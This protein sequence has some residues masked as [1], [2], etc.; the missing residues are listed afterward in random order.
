MYDDETL[1]QQP[2]TTESESTH[3]PQT[4]QPTQEESIQAKNFK[5]LKDG[6]ER[7]RR[8][9]ER[10]ER[11]RDE[12][13]RRMAEMESRMRSNQGHEDEDVGGSDDDLIDKKSFRKG[14]ERERKKFSE[15]LRKQQSQME[16]KL[17]EDRLRMMYPDI[18]SVLS[19]ENIDTFRNIEPDMARTISASTDPYG[20]AVSAYKMIKK[21]GIHQDPHDATL[22]QKN[23]SKPRPAASV[24]ATQG[25]SPLTKAH[26]Y[27]S[28]LTEERKRQLWKE[29]QD[30][31]R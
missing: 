6:Y 31:T 3:A 1:N 9:R 15:E 30:A 28:G 23:L 5:A 13:Y 16:A 7:E 22:V 18:E 4:I 8:E 27:G 26:E 12:M 21:L 29:M 17:A 2:E 11:E 19:A 20:K 24:A 10:S 25:D 14:L